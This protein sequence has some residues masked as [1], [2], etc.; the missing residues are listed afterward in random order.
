[1]FLSFLI[2][3]TAGI[4]VKDLDSAKDVVALGKEAS[5][6]SPI[7]VSN[8]VVSSASFA[9]TQAATAQPESLI[10]KK[11]VTVAS[12]KKGPQTNDSVWNLKDQGTVDRVQ[13]FSFSSFF[14][15]H[16]FSVSLLCFLLLADWLSVV[17]RLWLQQEEELSTH[18]HGVSLHREGT[19]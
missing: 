19:Q 18:G 17:A 1:L 14:R 6:A 13:L 16:F 8:V 10:S 3:T 15:V 9:T 11:S 4:I 7:P 5:M 12:S 2:L